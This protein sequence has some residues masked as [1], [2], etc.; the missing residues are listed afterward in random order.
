[1]QLIQLLL[2]ALICEA[3]WE[4]LKLVWEKG[5]LNID[6]VGAIVIGLTI[7]FGTGADLLS[8]VDIPLFVP[9]V[10]TALTGILI[11]RGSNFIHDLLK[12]LEQPQE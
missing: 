6:R 3:V 10:G 8:L 5:S 2:L 1:M 4:T 11:S 9:Y 12:K 7:A